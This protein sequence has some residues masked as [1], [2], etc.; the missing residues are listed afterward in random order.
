M[1]DVT[2][3]MANPKQKHLH[4]KLAE[5]VMVSREVTW[6]DLDHGRGIDQPFLG[7]PCSAAR[8]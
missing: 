5:K 4:Y 2:C 1:L 7:F 8:A 6:Y 3:E